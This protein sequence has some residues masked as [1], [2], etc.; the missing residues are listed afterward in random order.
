MTYITAPDLWDPATEAALR[1]GLL[2]LTPGQ[3]IRC[4][5]GRCAVFAGISQ[6]GTVY[7]V[8]YVP[9]RGYDWRKFHALRLSLQAS[10]E[11]T[12]DPRRRA[13]ELARF[14]LSYRDRFPDLAASAWR[15]AKA[16]TAM[17]SRQLMAA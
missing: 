8:H 1:A 17:A 3:R 12:M 16:I 11:S 15:Q 13:Q 10:A 4:G 7:A 5:S 2:Q 9:G 6:A 14:A